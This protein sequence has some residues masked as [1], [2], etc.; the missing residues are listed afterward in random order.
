MNDKKW[1]WFAIGYQ[2][3]FAY[4]MSLIVYQVL[5]ICVNGQFGV[6]SVFAIALIIGLIYLLV[7]PSKS[8]Q[9]S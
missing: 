5:N 8:G 7:R 9:T 4:V 2:T 1:F 3:I 6:G